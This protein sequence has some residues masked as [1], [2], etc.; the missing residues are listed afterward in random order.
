MVRL[1]FDSIRYFS[2]P[3]PLADDA[4]DLRIESEG[5]TFSFAFAQDGGSF[6]TLEE[7][8]ARFLSSE[9]VGGF[10]GAYVGPYATGNGRAAAA[11]A[12][13]DFFE[14]LPTRAPN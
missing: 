5:P 3:Q 1:Q 9:T 8:S 6:R 4:V 2:D 11:P 13:F 10:T 14:Y 7:V 12:D